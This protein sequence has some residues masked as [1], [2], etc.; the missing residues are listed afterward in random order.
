MGS[1]ELIWVE[2]N[3]ERWLSLENLPN[4]E[5]KDIKDFEGLYQI[6]NYGRVKRLGYFREFIGENQ[7]G[8][9]KTKYSVNER[10]LKVKCDRYLRVQ[11]YKSSSC[12]KYYSTHQLVGT[13]FIPNPKNK[14][15]IDHINNNPYD[16][17]MN[18]LQWATYKENTDYAWQRGRERKFGINHKNSK[19]IGQYSLDGTLLNTYYGSGE[20][21]R[22]TGIRDT[23]IRQACRAGYG[24]KT[25]GGYIWKYI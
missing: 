21:S 8:K 10:I 2:P 22:A 1:N 6:S 4:E 17:R 9:F 25:R 16:N 5:W 18:N 19:K 11:L 24:C 3:S 12:S 7:F 15:V 20:A 23:T 13:H 14:P